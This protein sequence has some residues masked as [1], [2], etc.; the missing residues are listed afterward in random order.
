MNVSRNSRIRNVCQRIL[1]R[2]ALNA[3]IASSCVA[4][5]LT[6]MTVLAPVTRAGSCPK[7]GNCSVGSGSCSD[8]NCSC[9]WGSE[10]GVG[11]YC[12]YPD[13]L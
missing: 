9:Q 3:G 2:V 6:L 13:S 12:C 11:C 4:L 5:A 7:G 1:G 8:G 10:G